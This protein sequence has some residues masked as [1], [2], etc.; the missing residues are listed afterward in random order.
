[1]FTEDETHRSF[2]LA[3]YPHHLLKQAITEGKRIRKYYSGNFYPLTTMSL[4]ATAWCVFQYHRTDENDGMIMAF[5]RSQSEQTEFALNGL[6]EI[7]PKANY[8]VTGYTGSMLI[9][10]E[11][12]SK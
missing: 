3:D 10:Y 1:M 9:E 2:L 5:R 7:D 6:R 8:Q 4:D 11:K 12:V